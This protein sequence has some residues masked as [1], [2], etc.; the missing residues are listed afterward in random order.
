MEPVLQIC[1][2][3]FV[4]FFAKTQYAKQDGDIAVMGVP[5]VTPLSS[6]PPLPRNLENAAEHT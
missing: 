4:C 6:H 3:F 5:P 2:F 1:V